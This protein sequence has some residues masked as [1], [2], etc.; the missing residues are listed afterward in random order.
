M[1]V[2]DPTHLF[3]RNMIFMWHQ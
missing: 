2:K 1:K 3:A